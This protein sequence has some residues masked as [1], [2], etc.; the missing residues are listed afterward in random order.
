MDKPVPLHTIPSLTQR[1]LAYRERIL[2]D[3]GGNHAPMRQT[4]TTHLNRLFIHPFVL[5]P[6]QPASIFVSVPGAR[7]TISGSEQLSGQLALTADRSRRPHAAL[8]H[9]MR[10]SDSGVVVKVSPPDAT[11]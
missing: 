3:K 11:K 4:Q 2:G 5:P 6:S 8:M 1:V 9:A 7:D 10:P